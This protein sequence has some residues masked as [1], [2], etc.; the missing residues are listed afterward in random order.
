MEAAASF[1]QAAGTFAINWASAHPYKAGASAVSIGLTPI[2]GP[3]WVIALPLKAAGFG[4]AGVGGGKL[5]CC[6]WGYQ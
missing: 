3:G 4:A 5:V 6:G 2:L 1:A